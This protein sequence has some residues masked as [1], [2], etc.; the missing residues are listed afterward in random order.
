MVSSMLLIML[1]PQESMETD[2]C[3]RLDSAKSKRSTITT[4]HATSNLYLPYIHLDVSLAP[5]ILS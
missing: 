4:I 5:R 1:P 3:T 2:L